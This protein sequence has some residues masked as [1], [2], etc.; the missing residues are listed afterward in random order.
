MK[1]YLIIL[2]SLFIILS[3]CKET[4]IQPSQTS[5]ETTIDLLHADL[6]RESNSKRQQSYGNYQ[7]NRAN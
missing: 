3:G 1:T 2:T 6:D 4:I 7:P 5:K